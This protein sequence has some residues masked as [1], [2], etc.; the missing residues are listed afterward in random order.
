ME[1]SSRLPQ[2]DGLVGVVVGLLP[3]DGE[4]SSGIESSPRFTGMIAEGALMM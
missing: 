3:S 1:N 2:P 4:T